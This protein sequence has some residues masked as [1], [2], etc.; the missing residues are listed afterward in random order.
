RCTRCVEIREISSKPARSLS[1]SSRSPNRSKSAAFM[2]WTKSGIETPFA[3]MAACHAIV[4][5]RMMRQQNKEQAEMWRNDHK[6]GFG[7]SIR[8]YDWGDRDQS[9][10]HV[11]PPSPPPAINW[12]AGHRQ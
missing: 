4:A 2:S 1:I 3:R 10:A 9:E 11:G 7:A 12:L 6:P 5:W 8:D